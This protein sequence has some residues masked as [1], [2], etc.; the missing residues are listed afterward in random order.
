MLENAGL[1]WRVGVERLKNRLRG[2]TRIPFPENISWPIE[3]QLQGGLAQ[4]S[5]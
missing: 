2:I 4:I 5:L 3:F 1:E